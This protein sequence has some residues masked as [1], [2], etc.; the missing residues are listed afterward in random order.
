[1]VLMLVRNRY[2]CPCILVS[3]RVRSLGK[4]C[5]RLGGR[6]VAGRQAVAVYARVSTEEQAERQSI[7]IQTDA[8]AKHAALHGLAVFDTY[9]DDGVSGMLPLHDRPEG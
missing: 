8:A 4:I 6:A 7:R 2:D 5:A 1:M 9:A 3:V